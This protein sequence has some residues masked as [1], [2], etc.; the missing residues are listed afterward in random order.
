MNESNAQLAQ[1]IDPTIPLI[2]SKLDHL[3]QAAAVAKKT[4]RKRTLNYAVK[5]VS[6]KVPSKWLQ[7]IM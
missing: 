5:Q 6:A 1:K 4:Q 2:E 7:K 3:K